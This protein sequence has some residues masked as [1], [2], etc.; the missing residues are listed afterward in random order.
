MSHRARV[1]AKRQQ[2]LQA[3][4]KWP[5]WVVAVAGAVAGALLTAT[6]FIIAQ[7][8]PIV[9]FSFVCLKPVGCYIHY[10]PFAARCS[11]AVLV[12]KLSGPF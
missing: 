1:I 4:S 12:F 10:A 9:R 7:T 5:T 3:S 2:M 8:V 11:A 6:G